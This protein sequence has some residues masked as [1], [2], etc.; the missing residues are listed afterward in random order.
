MPH[1]SFL[2]SIFL[3][4]KAILSFCSHCRTICRKYLKL[5]YVITTGQSG[6]SKNSLV[7]G[8]GPMYHFLTENRGSCIYQL[9][10]E[11]SCEGTASCQ[12]RIER[13]KLKYIEDITWP[14]GDTEISL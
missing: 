6:A 10:H 4:F 8:R 1:H 5:H 2:K 12:E 14:R 11:L 7:T 13:K 9:M 3:F